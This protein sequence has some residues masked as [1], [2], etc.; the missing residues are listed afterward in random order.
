MV[1]RDRGVRRFLPWLAAGTA[2]FIATPG[3]TQTALPPGAVVQPLGP[4]RGAELRQHLVTL[5]SN[6]NSLSALIGAGRAALDTGDAQAALSF[7]GRAERIAPGDARVLAGMAS[8]FARTEQARPALNL[9]AQAVSAGAPE[10]EI[11]A[12]RGLAYDLIGNPRAAQ[13]DYVRSL[14]RRDDPEVRRR[15]AIS[16]A[17]SGHREA[18]LKVIETQLRANDRAA[19]RTRTLVHA[20]TGDQAGAEAAAR[21]S[22]PAQAVPAM[23]PFLSR[24]SSLSPEQKA[25]AA[26]FGHFPRDGQARPTYAGVDTSPDPGA[27]ALAGVGAAPAAPAQQAPVRMAQQTTAPAPARA[28]ARDR[29]R[30]V[31]GS[32]TVAASTERRAAERGTSYRDSFFA[33]RGTEITPRVRQRE[34]AVQVA[35][36]RTSAPPSNPAPG[37]AQ[38]VTQP[39]SPPPVQSAPSEPVAVQQRAVAAAVN[40]PA[41][42]PPPFAPAP[43]P[44]P[45]PVAQAEPAEVRPQPVPVQTFSLAPSAPAIA[46]EAVPGFTQVAAAEPLPPPA[47]PPPPSDVRPEPSDQGL[48]Q[49]AALLATL[50]VEE[51]RVVQAARAPEPVRRRAEP[52]RP[53]QAPAAREPAAAKPTPRATTPRRSAAAE[54]PD[55][56]NASSRTAARGADRNTQNRT[57]SADAATAAEAART[58]TA[59]NATERSSRSRGAQPAHPSRHWIQLSLGPN[60]DVLPR[61]FTRLKAKA[62]AVFG[63]RSPYTVAVRANHRLLVGPFDDEAAARAF[64]NQLAREGVTSDI[65]VSETGQEI[66]RLSTPTRR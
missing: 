2:I 37:V 59:R 63:S 55:P 62:P 24:L 25:L 30:A 8:A 19:W 7:F 27:L 9:F 23:L 20:V 61:E 54:Q 21:F 58:S 56:P 42:V 39:A 35:A 29:A 3:A 51:E 10:A 34:Q 36:A 4:D 40:A 57:R 65:F 5:A 26:H 47:S 33:R 17:V 64:M 46:A 32:N 28:N 22:L 48:A 66:A 31:G 13:A 50:P 60:A 41:L 15:L 43:A 45:Q 38:P 1:I 49:V 44:A 52:P 14:Q 11:A 12:D 16:L 6:P 53:L 18:A